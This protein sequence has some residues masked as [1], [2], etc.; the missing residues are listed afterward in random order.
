MSA[1]VNQRIDTDLLVMLEEAVL[2]SFGFVALKD[3]DLKYLRC[4]WS[5]ANLFKTTP[6]GIIGK[7]NFDLLPKREAEEQTQCD[8]RIIQTQEKTEDYLEL[9]CDGNVYEV[10]RIKKPIISNNV[11]IGLIIK[12]IDLTKERRLTRELLQ[13]KMLALRSSAQLLE[14]ISRI[15]C[16]FV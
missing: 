8:L 4:N 5:F 6:D 7:T 3:K 16:N 15:N 9:T 2:E 14:D 12:N 11:V 13:A 1:C 10:L